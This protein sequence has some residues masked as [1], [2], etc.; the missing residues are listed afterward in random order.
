MYLDYDTN[1]RKICI[2]MEIISK[3][4]FLKVLA[5]PEPYETAYFGYKNTSIYKFIVK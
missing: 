5:H 3:N 1:I 4:T 2:L